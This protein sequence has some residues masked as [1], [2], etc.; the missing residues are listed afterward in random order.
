M[1]DDERREIARVYWAELGDF[2]VDFLKRGAS[3][4]SCSRQVQGRRTRRWLPEQLQRPRNFSYCGVKV[5]LL[6]AEWTDR[7]VIGQQMKPG[8][9]RSC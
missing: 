2:L 6:P 7:P 1:G 3:P 8:E 9:Q 5:P 4:V